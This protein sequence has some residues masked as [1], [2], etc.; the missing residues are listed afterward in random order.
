ME[1]RPCPIAMSA[2]EVDSDQQ[3]WT[4]SK[5]SATAKP[6]LVGGSLTEGISIFNP[7]S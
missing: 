6:N 4:K 1:F 2:V 7:A 3:L 5:V